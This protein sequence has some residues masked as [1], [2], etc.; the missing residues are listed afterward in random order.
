MNAIDLLKAD[1]EKVKA[2]LTQLSES[3]ERGVKKRT[4]LLDKLEMEVSIHTQLEEQI[5][6]PA[7]KA[8]GGKDEAEMYY[9]AKE[10]HRTVDSLVLPDL[11]ATDPTSP[12]F[13]GRVKVVKE[14]LE[15]H[16][17]EEETEMFPKAKKLLGKA[18]L[19]KL[20]EQMLAMKSSLKKSYVSQKVAA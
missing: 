18:E 9:E 13:A 3:T 20:G 19:E 12:E 11:K 10:E 6:Y 2:I 5:L 17:E 1:H 16:I 15:H 7:F 4:E 14:L 8:A